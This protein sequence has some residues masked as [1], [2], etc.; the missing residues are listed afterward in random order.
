MKIIKNKIVL[1]KDLKLPFSMYS[2]IEIDKISI[3]FLSLILLTTVAF[4]HFNNFKKATLK[5]LTPN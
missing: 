1:P 4:R 2:L 5:Y 3:F